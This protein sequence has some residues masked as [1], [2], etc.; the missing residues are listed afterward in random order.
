V[1]AFVMG[2]ID[3]L[4]ARRLWPVA[5]LML[6]VLVAVP[7]LMLKPAEEV[8]APAPQATSSPAPGGLPGPEEAL[9]GG[10]QPLVSL[11]SLSRSSDLESFEVKNPFKPI[12][13]LADPLGDGLPGGGQPPTGGGGP[14]PD[15]PGVSDVPSGG[16]TGGGTGGSD[17]APDT[18]GPGGSGGSPPVDPAPPV[19]PD[20]QPRQPLERLSYTVDLTF[21]GPGPARRYRNLPRLSMLPSIEEPRFVF[22]GVGASGNDAV[23]LV[24]ATLRAVDGEGTC[25]PSGAECATLSIEPGEEMLFVDEQDRTYYLRLDQIRIRPVSRSGQDDGRVQGDAGAPDDTGANAGAS[26][27]GSAAG[28]GRPLR[29]FL[30]PLTDLLVMGG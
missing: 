7:V 17:P 20:P 26:R 6:L 18:G 12:E 29:R 28:P 30:P 4:R 27:S 22:L 23:F 14:A 1:N 13:S 16:G 21:D 2:V 10:G 9:R 25:S 3:D 8:P 5:L 11:A 19:R 24:D 15:V